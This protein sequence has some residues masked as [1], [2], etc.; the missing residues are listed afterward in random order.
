[1]RG[2]LQS[3]AGKVE[4]GMIG[5][6]AVRL[7]PA[8]MVAIAAGLQIL[9]WSLVP[10]LLYAA[11]PLDVVEGYVHGPHWALTTLKHPALPSWL[12]EA[13]RWLTGA[14][15]W[16]AYVLSQL[17]IAATFGLV[18]RLG[19]ELLDA[20]RAAAGTL[21]LTG[22]VYFAWP[23]IEFNHNV[24]LMP[25]WTGFFYCLWRA[26]DDRS[27]LWWVVTAVIAAAM[28]HTKL[29][30]AVAFVAAGI[31]L[32]TDEKG[33][34]NLSRP[35]PWLAA[36]LFAA[37]VVPLY[38]SLRA[39]DFAPLVYA[40]ARAEGAANTNPLLFVLA[41]VLAALGLLALF[42]AAYRIARRAGPQRD[43]P[44]FATDWSDRRMR[45][46]LMAGVM[47]LLLVVTL[48]LLSGAGLR[49][50]WAA[51]MMSLSG[52]LA[53]ALM[54]ASF[55]RTHIRPIFWGAVG[56]LVIAPIVFGIVHLARGAYELRPARAHWPQ[57][58]IS[59]ALRALWQAET[60][61]PLRH[62]A[63]PFW[64]AGLVALSGSNMPIVVVDGDL[65]SAPGVT[66]GQLQRDGVLIVD[67]AGRG[68]TS[69]RLAGLGTLT[70]GGQMTFP[71]AGARRGQSVTLTWALIPPARR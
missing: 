10:A 55:T 20:P 28:L 48:A 23:S 11:S 42:A 8:Q 4:L 46:L 16:P 41:Q 2:E 64:P 35:A 69:P 26:V 58:E 40:A 22:V 38:L 17:C 44:D 7:I 9:L 47:P 36:A 65:A 57:A 70:K 52:L 50:S 43:D 25:L 5:G 67:V 21:V 51:S 54:G 14:V 62:V 59:R 60:G 33:R 63:G 19:R 66:I 71:I 15:G 45:F 49:S 31:W 32:L 12:L 27:S 29:S 39:S 1:M 13:S 18:Y 53:V 34:R 3:T 56:L 68:E 61:Q 37:L 24:A 30:S 6:R